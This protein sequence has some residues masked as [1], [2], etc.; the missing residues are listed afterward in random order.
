MKILITGARG[1]FATAL[2]PRLAVSGHELVLFDLEPMNAP[3][4]SISIQADIRDAAALTHAM[5]GCQ[6]VVHSLAYHAENA[7]TRNDADFYSVNVTGTHNVL[8]AMQLHSIESLV[9]S[10]CDSVYGDGM[11]G[12]R[13]MDE[14][15]PCIPTHNYALTKLLGEQMC[16]FYARCHGFKIAILRCGRFAP[17][18]WRAAGM[19]RLDHWLDREDV[20]Q[21]NEL[22]LGAVV[23]EEFKCETFLIQCAK[24]FLEADWPELE[25]NPGAVVE[26]YYPGAIELLAEHGLAVPKI[27]TRYNID[28]A[29]T[30]LGYAPQHNFGQFLARLRDL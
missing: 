26:H 24:P 16:H 8:R 21:A 12:V 30:T 1:N 3:D 7:E 27:H 11:R 4:R 13:V 10:S 5:Q 9:F 6:A 19:G 18:D 20:A 2:I 22:A 15:V 14:R 29:V 25:K 28:K 23:A 17:A